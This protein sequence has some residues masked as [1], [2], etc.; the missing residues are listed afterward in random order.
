MSNAKNVLRK[1]ITYFSF[2]AVLLFHSLPALQAQSNGN[3]PVSV[4]YIG[5]VDQQPVFQVEFENGEEKSF[6]VSIRDEE[7]NLLYNERANAKKFS[8]K[9]QLEK[10]APESM[11]LTITLTREKEKQSQVFEINTNVRVI[12]D[13]VITRL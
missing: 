10:S 1:T 3:N 5:L 12:Q 11:K 9:F 8:R 7:G 4:R 2:V 6:Q 13:V